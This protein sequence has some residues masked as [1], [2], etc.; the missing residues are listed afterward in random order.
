MKFPA[1]AIAIAALMGASSLHAQA[2]EAR[3]AGTEVRDA[4][5]KAERAGERELRHVEGAVQQRASDLQ[6]PYPGHPPCALLLV[7][8]DA[9]RALRQG[10]QGLA[11]P[12]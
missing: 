9:R 6:L 2:S 12:D 11:Q 5:F 10:T 4:R 7:R 1:I 3:V 8:D